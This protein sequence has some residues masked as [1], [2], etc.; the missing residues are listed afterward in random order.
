MRVGVVLPANPLHAPYLK[1]YIDILKEERIDFD[2]IYWDK[3]GLKESENNFVAFNYKC[4]YSTNKLR[5][6][7]GYYLFSKFVVKQVKK[8]KYNKLIVLVPQIAFFMDGF[9]EKHYQKNYILD[10]RDSSIVNKFEGKLRNI[11][12]NSKLT[13]ISSQGFKKWLPHEEEYIISHNTDLKSLTCQEFTRLNMEAKERIVISNIGSIRHYDINVKVINQ[14]VNS[15]YFDL[16]FIGTG[17]CEKELE[18]YCENNQIHNID[19]YGKYKKEEEFSFYKESDLINLIM[20]KGSIGPQ[21][22]MANRIYN[23]CISKR[24]VIVT[25]G[26]YM[27]EIVKTYHL[28][29]II[30]IDKD[31]LQ[32][33]INSYIKEF[34]FDLF[35]DGCNEFLKIVKDEEKKFVEE[36]KLFLR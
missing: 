12:R 20:P 6:L 25:E 8:E 22:S 14:F 32:K 9:L 4:D 3:L 23:A 33:E 11:I 17:V 31:D 18:S 21:T 2:I 34:D 27:A 36:V 7:M 1:Y 19:F 28:G 30:D 15:D 10:I 29:L 16:K 26:T 35:L 24:P 5:K 13:A